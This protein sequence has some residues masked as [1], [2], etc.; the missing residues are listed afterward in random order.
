MTLGP[1]YLAYPHRRQGLDHDLF[2]HRDLP[3]APRPRWP[4]DAKLALWIA[5]P[6]QHFPMDMK[7][8][9]VAIPGGMER[10]YPSYWDYTQRDYGNRVG[11]F[12]LM[13]ALDARGLRATAFVS[14]CIPGR[15]PALAAE[16]GA[17]GWEVAAS[18]WDMGHALHA[19]LPE[20]E[21]RGIIARSLDA[22]EQGFGTRPAGWHSP[23][24]AQS[25]RTTALLAA[26]GIAWCAD[27]I[28]DDLPF[29]MQ[30]PPGA[31]HALPLAYEI[32]DRRML[33]EGHGRTADWCAAVLAA[34]ERLSAEGGRI[35]C[36]HLTPWVAGQAHRIR[37]VEALLD[38]LIAGGA[39]AATG[40]EILGEWRK[41]G[42]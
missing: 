22:L 37:A 9:P 7:R 26:A 15:Y 18:S 40:S 34:A 19:G 31:L 23:G 1:D 38:Q 21:E 25:P 33:F 13:R 29:A 10:P 27:W 16:I 4:G 30:T 8:A 42:G 24:H 14:G 39:W 11:I 32:A 28:N 12:R 35:L 5:V 20:D 36:L 2:P 6:V 41:A 17:R 3:D